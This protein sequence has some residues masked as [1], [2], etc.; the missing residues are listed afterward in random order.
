MLVSVYVMERAKHRFLLCP[1]PLSCLVINK[2]CLN[3]VRKISHLFMLYNVFL[4]N[5][6]ESHP[7]ASELLRSAAIS[8]AKSFV[9]GCRL[10]MRS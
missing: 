6:N 4:A 8:V 3:Q 5:L 2:I 1:I 7:G 10:S 9:P